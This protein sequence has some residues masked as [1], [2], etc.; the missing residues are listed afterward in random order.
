MDALRVWWV[1]LGILGAGS[2]QLQL[3]KFGSILMDTCNSTVIIPC[4]VT[5]LQ[6]NDTR[7]MYVKW[8]L[9]GNEFFSFDGF[10]QPVK[11]QRNSTFQSAEFVSLSKL[12]FGTASLSLSRK[13]AIPGNYSCE[14]TESNREGISTVELK[15]AIESWFEPVENT[16]I[17]I[18]MV[19]AA[20][21]YWTQIGVV[22]T[23]F[24]ISLLKKISLII[25]GLIVTIA[26][27]IGCVLFVPDGFESSN[28]VGLGLIVLPAVILVPL[29]YILLTSVF[30]KPPCFAVMLLVLKAL[31][32]VI[33]VTGFAMSVSACPPQHA[34]VVIAGLAVID[35]VAVIALV[36]VII[37]GSNFKDHQPP[38]KAV[39]EPLNA[40]DLS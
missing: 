22:A 35:L 20:I 18:T 21:F 11:I 33:A 6:L 36:Y 30:E 10:E 12:P 37:I 3:Q 26:V 27:V 8:R 28:Q 19:L 1:L 2:A 38:R 39:E 5:N 17:I 25:A 9:G 29:L 40:H 15:Q 16:L 31:G 32:Y 7:A 4:I 13:E 34:A 14:V 23:K 24:D